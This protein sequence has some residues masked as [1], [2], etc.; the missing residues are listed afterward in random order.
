[1]RNPPD[2]DRELGRPGQGPDQH[3]QREI[4]DL[5]ILRPDGTPTYNFAVVVDDWDM[6]ITHVFR[7]DEHINNTPWQI[8]ILRALGA[9]LPQ[10]GHCPMIL[11]DDGQKL[12]KR[13]GA[14]SVMQPTR[15]AATCP[16][17]CSTTWRGWA[18]A[19]ATT[20]CSAASRWCSGSTAATWR[21]P[22]AVG[23]GQAGWVNAHYIKQAD[24]AR[25]ARTGGSRSNWP[26]RVAWPADAALA[27]GLRAVQG[28]LQPRWSNWPTGWACMFVRRASRGRGPGR[29]RHDACARR[30]AL[31]DALADHRLGQGHDRRRDE[32]TLATSS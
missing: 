28:P 5:I 19:M 3:Q 26:A 10:F 18:G 1:L 23:P 13:R 30:S 16:R 2:G 6:G 20:S 31:R 24:E 25:L 21:E 32:G 22:G 17:R 11:G 27:A 7:G 8:N 9:P 29:A 4:D 12:S 15:R 14:V